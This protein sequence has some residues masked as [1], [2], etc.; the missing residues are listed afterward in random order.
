M[1]Q[2]AHSFWVLIISMSFVLNACVSYK[3]PLATTADFHEKKPNTIAVLPVQDGRIK[4]EEMPEL[5]KHLVKAVKFRGY[6]P[7]SCEQTK[8][9]LAKANI[10]GP[11]VYNTDYRDLC[12][13]LGVDAVLVT[14]LDDYE[15]HYRGLYR[16][17]R[18]ELHF[19]LIDGKTGELLWEDHFARH[20]S[21]IAGLLGSAFPRM[22]VWVEDDALA[23]MPFGRGK[24][25]LTQHLRLW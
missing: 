21:K 6:E 4:K 16:T 14:R 24:P 8:E 19:K 1:G 15:S 23:K 20:E 11:A 3:P 25:D 22:H 2:R 5:E 9:L 13:T 10:T 17:D 7:Q 18:I 12:K